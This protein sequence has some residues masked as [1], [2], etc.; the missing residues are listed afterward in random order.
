M[1]PRLTLSFQRDAP[2][3]G[4]AAIEEQSLIPAQILVKDAYGDDVFL[5]EGIDPRNVEDIFLETLPVPE[6]W[7]TDEEEE[8]SQPRPT[9]VKRRRCSSACTSFRMSCSL[10]LMS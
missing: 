10:R 9:F 5:P 2:P 6:G 8:V 4:S 7:S 1:L 3:G